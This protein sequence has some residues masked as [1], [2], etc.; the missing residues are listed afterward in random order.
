[1]AETIRNRKD[2][3][4]LKDLAITGEDLCVLPAFRADPRLIG[5]ALQTALQWVLEDP[6]ANRADLLLRRLKALYPPHEC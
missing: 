5:D 3:L 2:P 6:C 1:M 4:T